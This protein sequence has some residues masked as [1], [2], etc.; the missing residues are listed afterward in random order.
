MSDHTV[1]DI[2]TPRPLN[3]SVYLTLAVVAV[4][5]LITLPSLLV[6]MLVVTLCVG[7]G[8]IYRFADPALGTPR[9]AQIYFA[10]QT[11]L[12]TGLSVLASGSDVF[13][14]LFFIL[15]IQAV[16]TLP[17]RVA[18]AWIALFYLLESG[19]AFWYRG[20]AGIINVLFNAAV[21]VLTFVFAN[22][23]RQAEIARLQN[24][25]LVEELQAV[26]RQM[27]DLAAA[28]E[29]NRLARDLHDSVKQQVLRMIAEG[30]N[31]AEIAA[32]LVLSEKTV[33]GHV[34]NIFSKLHLADR[35]QAAVFAWRAGLARAE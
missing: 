16:L 14:L 22:A 4:I 20:Q 30:L 9:R 11:L 33:K 15:G 18:I 21:F 17:T 25:R 5:G 12:L 19:I 8:I 26:Q 2:G 27:Q 3:I 7:F 23:L 24:E 32:R 13:G 1:I 34:G 31:N 28:A 29:R 35:T 6:R 10:T